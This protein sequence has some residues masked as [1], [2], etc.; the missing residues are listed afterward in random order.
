LIEG[1]LVGFR[2]LP[3][4][5]SFPTFRNHV[6]MLAL[7]GM[8]GYSLFT[9]TSSQIEHWMLLHPLRFF[10]LVPAGALAY[11]ILR[12]FRNEIATVDAS[13]IFRDQP[14]AAV[15]TLDLSAN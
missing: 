13:L 11:E 9:G 1:L 7:I 5:C 8:I 10:W 4:T 2:K 12:R 6:V 3:F 14:R 15:T